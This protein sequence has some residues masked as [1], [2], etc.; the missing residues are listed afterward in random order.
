ML[1]T[2]LLQRWALVQA[3]AMVTTALV[4][5]ARS[6]SNPAARSSTRDLF[7]KV[8]LSCVMRAG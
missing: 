6:G 8:L 1:R 5:A 3:L 4:S 2:R 7:Q